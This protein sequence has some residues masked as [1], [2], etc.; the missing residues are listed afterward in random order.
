[1][2]EIKFMLR[3]PAMDASKSETETRN[4]QAN[5]QAGTPGSGQVILM[6]RNAPQMR[7]T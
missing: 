3:N 2:D 5:N 6:R 4:V 7:L 1:M